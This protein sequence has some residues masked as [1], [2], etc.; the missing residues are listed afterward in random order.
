VCVSGPPYVELSFIESSNMHMCIVTLYISSATNYVWQCVAVCGSAWLCA[1]VCCSVWQ[2]VAVCC[3]VLQCV[4]VCGSV[5]QC[6]AARYSVLQCV[7]VWGK[8]HLLPSESF[9]AT[10]TALGFRAPAK[11]S[12][13]SAL[14]CS[15]ILNLTAR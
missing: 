15:S 8:H 1:A 2:C 4:A 3:S 9:A 5:W 12:Q 13:K 7:A 14:Q 10:T 11:I 6:A